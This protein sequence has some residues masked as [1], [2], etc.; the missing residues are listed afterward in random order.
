M[1]RGDNWRCPY[2]SKLDFYFNGTV[3]PFSLNFVVLSA[4]PQGSE[5]SYQTVKDTFGMWRRHRQ[6]FVIFDIFC[7]SNTTMNLMACG[8]QIPL[9]LIEEQ[10]SY[11]DHL[12]WA[13]LPV[14]HMRCNSFVHSF[15]LYFWT[16]RSKAWP[17]FLFLAAWT[18]KQAL[19]LTGRYWRSL[20]GE[21]SRGQI[22]N[23]IRRAEYIALVGSFFLVG[24]EAL[25]RILTLALRKFLALYKYPSKRSSINNYTTLLPNIPAAL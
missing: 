4:K 23:S 16:L 21:T 24:L 8:V 10:K 3:I 13:S 15:S 1:V 7:G 14:L 11:D 6:R 20:P 18:C 12:Y 25:I 5:L 17:L 2:T 19:Y 9:L 22:A